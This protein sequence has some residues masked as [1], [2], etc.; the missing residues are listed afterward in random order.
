VSRVSDS[1]GGGSESV[2]A[3]DQNLVP[4]PAHEGQE[5]G[6]RRGPRVPQGSRRHHHRPIG[7]MS[8]QRGHRPVVPGHA[9]AAPAASVRPL[10]ALPLA[11]APRAPAALEAGGAGGL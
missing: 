6:A 8:A 10:G 2:G 7:G 5:V 4:E 1:A 11:A 3:A 9:D